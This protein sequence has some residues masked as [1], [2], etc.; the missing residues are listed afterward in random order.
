MDYQITHLPDKQKFETTVD[1][2]VAYVVYQIVDDS[3]D[4]VHTIVPRPIEGRG[5]AAA[6]VK[7]AYTFALEKGLK[8]RGSCSYAKM[9]LIRHPEFNN[10]K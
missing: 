2:Y 3:L 4:I 10:E 6:L 5:I 8:L 7:E 1:G 9:W